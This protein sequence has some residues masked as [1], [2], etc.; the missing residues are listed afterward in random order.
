MTSPPDDVPSLAPDEP[1]LQETAVAPLDQLPTGS[2]GPSRSTSGSW[3]VS[4]GS[5]E[6]DLQTLSGQA[7]GGRYRLIRLLGKGGMGA[8]FEAVDDQHDRRCA[9]K[10]VLGGDRD[11]DT[12]RRFLRE[13]RAS[14]EIRSEHAVRVLDAETD[15]KRNIPYIVME[16]LTGEDLDQLVKRVGPL[17]PA[18][19]CQ[20]FLQA[21]DGLAAAHAQ[22]VIHRDIKPAN[23]FLHRLDSGRIV[24]KVCDFGVAKQTGLDTSQTSELTQTGGMVGSPTY[25]SPEQA[26]SAK[27]VDHRT[28]IWSLA[29]S[30]YQALSG[31][32]PWASQSASLGELILA[33]CTAELTPLQDL[34]P[35]VSPDL[36]D[37]IHRGI[38]REPDRRYATIDEFRAALQPFAAPPE[39]L[40]LEALTSVS[41]S[42][43]NVV[44]PRATGFGA[45][46]T[47]GHSPLTEAAP[48]TRRRSP[49]F[50]P[51]AVFA[52]VTSVG[53][54]G[55]LA[56]KASSTPAPA[57]TVVQREI[58][59]VVSVAPPASAPPASPRV[60]GRLLVKGSP[61]RLSV[62]GQPRELPPSG[63]LLLE[64]APGDSFFVE[65]EAGKLRRP[66][67]KVTLSRD[68]S[69]SPP[70]IV[71]PSFQ[72][73]GPLPSLLP[74]ARSAP[75][76]T[77]TAPPTATTPPP[78]RP[79]TGTVKPREEF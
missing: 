43:R 23:L 70:E 52:G 33:I 29:I 3:G 1:S 63:E 2:R 66:A 44:A 34:A 45:S 57:T 12:M 8:V 14:R 37:A 11:P 5:S 60:A 27:H 24:T 46:R 79:P 75:T 77:P 55:V 20:L 16:L 38:Q 64:G 74:A 22:G 56:L 73:G 42:T 61:T 19:T 41:E 54:T 62:N 13:A 18:A 67:E 31:Q 10:I 28:D 65:I 48:S 59:T 49:L 30:M 76:T 47:T 32:K 17:D 36:A 35:W 15:E 58:V 53:I 71:V 6:A 51:I 7:L 25:M 50:V 40:T 21:C 78:P 72:L 39:R 69:V 9:I 68:G 4:L 26:R